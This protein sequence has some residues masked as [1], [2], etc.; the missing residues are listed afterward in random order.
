[1]QQEVGNHVGEVAARGPSGLDDPCC[2]GD[3]AEER[4]G[5]PCGS[6]IGAELAIALTAQKQFLDLRVDLCPALLRRAVENSA[7]VR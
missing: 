4:F 1:V 6:Q 2:A 7:S 3:K 5:Q